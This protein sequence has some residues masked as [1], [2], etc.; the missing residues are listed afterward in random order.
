MDAYLAGYGS[1]DSE[2]DDDS[3]TNKNLAV[4]GP[5]ARTAVAQP[6]RSY[7]LFSPMNHPGKRASGSFAKRAASPRAPLPSLA[8]A[9][10]AVERRLGLAGDVEDAGAVGPGGAAGRGRS[11]RQGDGKGEGGQGGDGERGQRSH[12]A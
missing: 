7:P 11:A 4:V 8:D 5:A 1:T 9:A 6:I 10:A 12:E 2:T 3:A